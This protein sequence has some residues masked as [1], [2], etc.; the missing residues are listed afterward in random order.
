MTPTAT[1]PRPVQA[2]ARPTFVGEV[3]QR[4]FPPPSPLGQALE[5]KPLAWG[6]VLV[7]TAVRAVVVAPGFYI[8]GVRDW[9]QVLLGAVASSLTVTLTSLALHAMTAAKGR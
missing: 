6:P 9:R 1:A 3:Q 4:V 2:P 8:A 5:G 7:G